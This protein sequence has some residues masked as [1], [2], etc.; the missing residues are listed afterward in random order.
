MVFEFQRLTAGFYHSDFSLVTS[1]ELSDSH[2]Q[3]SWYLSSRSALSRIELSTPAILLM[4]I[5]RSII[6]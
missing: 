2:S 1:T 5:G 4:N 6:I 3:Y